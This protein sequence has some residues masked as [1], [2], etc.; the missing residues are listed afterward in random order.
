MQKLHQFSSWRCRETKC[1]FCKRKSHLTVSG[2]KSRAC[3]RSLHHWCKV[4][5]L[6]SWP[7][8]P[9]IWPQFESRTT[10]SRIL[11]YWQFFLLGPMG[12]IFLSVWP[13]FKKNTVLLSQEN[14]NFLSH[15]LSFKEFLPLSTRCPKPLLDR[16]WV[17]EEGKNWG[18]SRLDW[19]DFH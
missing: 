9:R 18:K 16:F 13:M 17:M 14:R 10:C 6:F 1:R 7:Q 12:V 2:I 5:S 15:F 4:L 11:H 3:G 19:L 8:S